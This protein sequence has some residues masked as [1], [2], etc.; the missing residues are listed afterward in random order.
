[1]TDVINEYYGKRGVRFLTVLTMGL[2]IYAFFMVFGAIALAPADWWQTQ[3]EAIGVPDMQ[4]AF[5]AVFG[6]GMLIIVGSVAAFL[7]AQLVDVSVFHKIKSYTG[8]DK[9]WLRA[10]GSTVVSQ[11]IDTVVIL[12]IAFVIGPKLIGRPFWTWGQFFAVATVQYV[13]KFSMA[14]LLT[15]VI[16]WAHDR[17]DAFLGKE[18]AEAMKA[19]AGKW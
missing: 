18:V 11:L 8:E 10:T 16:Y 9:V 13:Y 4:A 3:N 1:M 15:P 7:L 17:I 14:V 12:L 5:S 6:Q 2:I 19:E